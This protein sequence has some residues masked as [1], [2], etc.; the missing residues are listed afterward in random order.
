[1]A[2]YIDEALMQHALKQSSIT[3]IIQSK[4]YHIQAPIGAKSPYVVLSLPVPSDESEQLGVR[5]FGQPLFQ[6]TCVSVEGILIKY[7]WSWG[8]REL[9]GVGKDD[10]ITC[11]VETEVHYEGI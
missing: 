3:D 8:P 7:S 9:S 2:T 11:I 10:D 5:D 4:L 6:W 1:M